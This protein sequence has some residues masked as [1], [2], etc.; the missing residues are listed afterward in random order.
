MAEDSALVRVRLADGSTVY[1]DGLPVDDTESGERDVAGVSPRFDRVVEGIRAF[2][3]EFVGVVKESG[4]AKMAVEFG[5][6][7]GVES[8]GALV[9][10][11]GKATGKS[12]LKVTLEWAS[13]QT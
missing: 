4:A 1:V 3:H 5:C 9:A 8:G 11:L 10:I 13:P 7:I 2:A 12:S 6:E